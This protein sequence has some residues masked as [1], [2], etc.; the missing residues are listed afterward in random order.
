MST[1]IQCFVTSCIQYYEHQTLIHDFELFSIQTQKTD[2][3]Y[4]KLELKTENKEH[5]KKREEPIEN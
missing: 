3:L 4:K 2:I 5:K 1:C